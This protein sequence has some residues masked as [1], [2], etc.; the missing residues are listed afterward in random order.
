MVKQIVILLTTFAI[1]VSTDPIAAQEAGKIYR[2]G[3]LTFAAQPGDN[4]TA[5][6]QGLRE[7]GYIEGQNIVIDWRFAQWKFY[8]LVEMAAEL[9]RLKVDVI[10]T[11]DQSARHCQIKIL[12]N[13]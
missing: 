4:E 10:I 2:I 12:G 7:P 8:R 6:R 5:L 13:F 3:Y 11:G 9:V 1:S